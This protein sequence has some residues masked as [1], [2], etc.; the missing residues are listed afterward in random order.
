MVHLRYRSVDNEASRAVN[1]R[2]NGC[3]KM[4]KSYY[5]VVT[6]SY[7]TQQSHFHIPGYY[8]AYCQYQDEVL[9]HVDAF[10]CFSFGPT[11]N[12]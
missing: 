11:G 1:H 5:G 7:R 4:H 12:I 9:P 8:T 10:S 6:V 2:L 3:K